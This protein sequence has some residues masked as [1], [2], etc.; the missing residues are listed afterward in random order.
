M[1]NLTN[2]AAVKAGIRGLLC[3]GVA[4]VITASFSW[5]FVASTETLNWMS[6]GADHA[7]SFRPALV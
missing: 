2:I 6:S 1:N 3:A 5:S 4:T 7:A